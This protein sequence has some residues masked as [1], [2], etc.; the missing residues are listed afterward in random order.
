MSVGKASDKLRDALF[1]AEQKRA[2]LYMRNENRLRLR[3][4][5]LR[6]TFVTLSLAMD[7]SEEWVMRRTGH[8]SS[9]TLAIYKRHAKTVK[10]LE[11]GWLH[12]M[13]ELIPELRPLGDGGRSKG[14]LRLVG[15][16][17]ASRDGTREG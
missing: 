7:R 8:M 14:H 10:E 2:Q 3:H 6:A 1:A 16:T 11:L 9:N 5:D 4:H 15:G 13:H 12:P 17:D